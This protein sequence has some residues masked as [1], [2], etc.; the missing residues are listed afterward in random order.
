MPHN[1]K[2]TVTPDQR[3]HNED[4][5]SERAALSMPSMKLQEAIE[6]DWATASKVA[7]RVGGLRCS[8]IAHCGF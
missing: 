5:P 6:E 1:I 8:S 4:T 3:P 7:Q 2:N